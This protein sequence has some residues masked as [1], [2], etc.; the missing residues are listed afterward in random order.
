MSTPELAPSEMLE[1]ISAQLLRVDVPFRDQIQR[2]LEKYGNRAILSGIR[3]FQ[4][5]YLFAIRERDTAREQAATHYRIAYSRF[6]PHR[7]IEA[8]R[9]IVR[10]NSESSEEE[11]VAA[12]RQ[13]IEVLAQQRDQA[14]F[15]LDRLREHLIRVG[16]EDAN[17]KDPMDTVDRLASYRDRARAVLLLVT[18]EERV[19]LERVLGPPTKTPSTPCGH[20]V[21]DIQ[22]TRDG[23]YFCRTCDTPTEP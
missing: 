17:Q 22:T 23:T 3:D 15:T 8:V 19:L 1:K 6:R 18:P 16:G 9:Q 11:L 2:G 21:E 4:V 13:H 20:P 7:L 12:L 10:G 14:N 5:E